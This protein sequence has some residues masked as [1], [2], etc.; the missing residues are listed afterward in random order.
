MG[1]KGA[2][3]R[4]KREVSPIF[5]PIH[6][7]EK[8]WAV[9]PSPGPHGVRESLPLLVILRDLLG[10]A[11]TRREAEIVM[12]EGK[13]KVDGKVRTDERFPVG[14]MDVIEIPDANQ[15]FRVLSSEKGLTLHAISREE[16][17]FKLC[18]IESKTTER[19][20]HVQINL[21]DG[22]NLMIKAEEPLRATD[23]IY[24][25]HDVLRI[26]A[27][28][29]EVMDH[30]RF[31]EGVLALVTGGK[32]RGL[33]GQILDIERRPGFPET[34]TLRTPEGKEIRT[35]IDYIFP[36]GVNSLLIS[37]PEAA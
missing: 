9:H 30:L 24:K 28:N 35:I 19:G 29:Q 13:V 2:K 27:P 3:E 16:S 31:G 4:I 32:S 21:H 14:L 7:K 33:Y 5:W 23:N 12:I 26:E 6:R 1:R 8:V 10:Y 15:C 18:R 37:L 11:E 22:R 25:I 36:V 20:G 17:K 34:V